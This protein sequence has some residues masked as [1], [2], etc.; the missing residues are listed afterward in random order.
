MNSVIKMLLDAAGSSDEEKKSIS[1]LVSGIEEYATEFVCGLGFL[2]KKKRE[3]LEKEYP[4]LFSLKI[5][6]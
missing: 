6:A 3:I 1:E 2:E 4:E 5:T